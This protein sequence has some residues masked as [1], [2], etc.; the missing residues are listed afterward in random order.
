MADQISKVILG[1][2]LSAAFAAVQLGILISF[3][4]DQD[5]TVVRGLSDT[6]FLA[7]IIAVAVFPVAMPSVVLLMLSRRERC[8]EFCVCGA[9][10]PLLS[11][12][13]YSGGNPRLVIPWLMSFG[14]CTYS[15][16]GAVSACPMWAICTD[17]WPIFSDQGDKEAGQ[18]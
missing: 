16:I 1:Y 8:I 13:L 5:I 17:R 7:V 10:C 18:P 11:T 15:L 2:L 3:L 14:G 6:L 12:T 4:S 9:L